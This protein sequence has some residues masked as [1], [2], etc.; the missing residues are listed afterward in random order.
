M[1]EYIC[2]ECGYRKWERDLSDM[3]AQ[4]PMYSEFGAGFMPS[5]TNSAGWQED[6]ICPNCGKATSWHPME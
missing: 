1:I 3:M 5:F 2:S 4:V 6:T